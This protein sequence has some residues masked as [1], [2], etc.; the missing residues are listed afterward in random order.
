MI[1]PNLFN[2]NVLDCYFTP[3]TSPRISQLYWSNQLVTTT[4][5]IDFGVVSDMA[6]V[7]LPGNTFLSLCVSE[8]GRYH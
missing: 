2:S 8:N 5:A 7:F 3:V 1:R 4:A 6:D